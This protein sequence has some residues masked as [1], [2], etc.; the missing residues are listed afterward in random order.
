MELPWEDHLIERKTESDL[1]D[2]LKTMV[3]FAN[4]VA[5]G[6]TAEILIGEKDDGTIQGVTNPDTIQ[7]KVR[8]TAEKIYPPIIFRTRGYDI[9]GKTCVRVEIDYDGQTPHFGGPAWVRR[10]SSTDSA[11]DEIFQRLIE[12]RLSKVR[13]LSKW[14]GKDVTVDFDFASIGQRYADWSS[15]PR[16]HGVR[17]N[18]DEKAELQAVNSFWVEL[19]RDSDGTLRSEPLD[20]ILLAFDHENDRLQIIVK[21]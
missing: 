21:A 12:L 4:S 7:K 17:W 19:F 2:L 13:E 11:S 18:R 20:K 15:S 5:P 8:E 6:H 16:V 14:V 10:G 9:S 1:K 3:A